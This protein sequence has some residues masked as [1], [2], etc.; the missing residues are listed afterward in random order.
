MSELRLLAIDEEDLAIVSAHCQDA[1]V[2]TAEISF[3][4]A[5]GRFVLV[6]NRFAWEEAGKGRR[7]AFTRRRDYE[8]RRAVLHFDRVR[9]VRQT[10]VLIGD[11]DQVL[12]LLALR[13]AEDEAPSGTVELV[14]AGGSAIRL[15]VECI[16]A[17]LTD[18][19]AAWST[20][21]RPDHDREEP[22]LIE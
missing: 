5:E 21:N 10:G 16:E 7:F 11:P 4:P 17:Q 9:A 1:V 22:G 20:Q 6:M 8:R 14:F 12:A 15:D 18:L 19:G 13:F 2:R 3:L